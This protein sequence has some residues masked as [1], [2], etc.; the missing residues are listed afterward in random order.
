MRT[1]RNAA[2]ARARAPSNRAR[3]A[4]AER[5]GAPAAQDG[6]YV[7]WFGLFAPAST[8][9]AIVNRL[10]SEVSGIVREPK[11]RATFTAQGLTAVGSGS[12]EFATK[13]D[14]EYGV[15][16]KVIREAGIKLD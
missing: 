2:P 6:G 14:R 9:A 11:L 12:Q 5:S 7:L 16:G 13:V 8:P 1:T 4:P 3:D 10:S 15:W